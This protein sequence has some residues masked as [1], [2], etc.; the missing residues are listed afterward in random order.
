MDTLQAWKSN[1][2]VLEEYS[3]VRR[4][5]KRMETQPGFVNAGKPSMAVFRMKPITVR[6]VPI[7]FQVKV[8]LAHYLLS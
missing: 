3:G 7:F 2:L 6:L 5:V 1:F 8:L 4:V